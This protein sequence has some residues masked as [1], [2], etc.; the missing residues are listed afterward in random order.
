MPVLCFQLRLHEAWQD[1]S[2]LNLALQEALS[3][4]FPD[5]SDRYVSHRLT[6]ALSETVS[7]NV[8]K[9]FTTA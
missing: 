6:V 8:L 3:A 4:H 5:C 9:Y 2:F 1:V 7:R